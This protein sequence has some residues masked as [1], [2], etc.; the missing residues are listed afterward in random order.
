MC[1][2]G[3]RQQVSFPGS[4][5]PRGRS[6]ILYRRI[7]RPLGPLM[8]HVCL[9]AGCVPMLFP[10]AWMFTS[11]LKSSSQVYRFPPI[12]VPRPLV[13]RNFVDVLVIK[14]FALYVFNT[15][16]ITTL[17]TVGT[18]L[19]ATMVA[20]AFAR[21]RFPSRDRLFTVCLSTMMLPGIVT[22]IPSYLLFRFLGWLDTYRPLVVP[23]YFGGGAFFIF[24][25]RQFF[26]S[27]PLDLDEAAR[28]D[29][30]NGWYI[31]LRIILPNSRPLLATMTVFSVLWNWNDFMGPFLYINSSTKLTVAVALH[32]YMQMTDLGWQVLM[33]AATLATLPIM[34][35]YFVA[36]R[37]IVQG[38][39]TSGLGGT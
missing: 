26:T 12:W 29:G 39:M 15:I 5:L 17:V 13:W 11:A 35:L 8:V 23:A 18:V 21:L 14:P 31:W 3:K 6:T 2:Q 1:Y 19:S 37:Y 30:A 20:Y 25:A 4:V 10:F 28:M 32:A 36:Q 38:I 9:L 16:T 33:A 7:K 24:L 27:I 34:V 22:M